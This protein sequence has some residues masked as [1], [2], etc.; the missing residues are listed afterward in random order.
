MVAKQNFIAGHWVDGA[1]VTTNINPSDISDVVGE[2]TQA[3][4]S[5][6]EEAIAAAKAAAPA[7]GMSTP[8]QRCDALDMIGNEILARKAEIGELLSREEG[9]TL[10]NG[11]GEATR[12]GQIFKFFAQEA[13]RV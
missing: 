5:Q 6:T 3:S 7:W 1:G 10:P 11:I 8:Q 2:F 12:A 13:L 4:K 9:K